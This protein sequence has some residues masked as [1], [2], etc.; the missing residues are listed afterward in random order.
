MYSELG[1]VLLAGTIFG[2]LFALLCILII[3]YIEYCVCQ[4]EKFVNVYLCILIINFLSELI[5]GSAGS[6]IGNGIFSVG[7]FL[8]SGLINAAIAYFIYKLS[9]SFLSYVIYNF[10]FSLAV[11]FIL[12]TGIRLF[13]STDA[14]ILNLALLIVLVVVVVALP[15][16]LIKK[17]KDNANIS[18]QINYNENINKL[19]QEQTISVPLPSAPKGCPKCGRAVDDNLTSC[20]HCGYAFASLNVMYEKAVAQKDI[21]NNGTH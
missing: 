4:T 15:I 1:Q 2:L 5:G 20:P 9:R 16:Y 8:L 19:P 17:K 18:S 21:H 3:L 13:I 11:I 12:L 6:I 7:V 10:L 14:S